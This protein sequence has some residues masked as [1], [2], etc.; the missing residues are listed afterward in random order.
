MNDA[1]VQIPGKLLPGQIFFIRNAKNSL[2][3]FGLGFLFDFRNLGGDRNYFFRPENV[4]FRKTIFHP[5]KNK[6]RS[7]WFLI[8]HPIFV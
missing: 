5:K 7:E 3:I 1:P 6:S 2:K 8:L 4:F